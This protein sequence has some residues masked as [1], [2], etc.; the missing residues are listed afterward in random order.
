MPG[1]AKRLEH[2]IH[3]I[4]PRKAGIASF[5]HQRL[6]KAFLCENQPAFSDSARFPRISA[7]PSN[8]QDSSE[9]ERLIESG[10]LLEPARLFESDGLSPTA[11]HERVTTLHSLPQLEGLSLVAYLVVKRLSGLLRVRGLL[12]ARAQSPFSDSSVDVL[13]PFVDS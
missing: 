13:C 5:S 9:S 8:Q 6:Q 3:D 11:F 1:P 2:S 7:T 4:S 12:I 10:R